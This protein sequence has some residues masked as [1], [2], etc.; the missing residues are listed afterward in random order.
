MVHVTNISSSTKCVGKYEE[1]IIQCLAEHF[2]KKD[3]EVIPHARFNIAWGIIISD[4][5]LLLLKGRVL[6]YVEVKS[7]RDKLQ[8][9]FQQIERVKDFVDYAYVATDKIVSDWDDPHVGLI[10]V[11]GSLVT[12][13]KE[14][15]QFK[16]SPSFSSIASLRKKCLLRFIENSH[17]C[18]NYIY[19]YDLAQH[20]HNFMR[21][22]CNRELLKEIVTCG[23]TCDTMCP[24]ESCVE[25]N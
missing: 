24:I 8:R 3:Y 6:I 10:S 23:N 11:N 9:A 18:S 13:V 15:K 25:R 19:K 1:K 2:R 12:L 22:K 4:I 14:T 5:D 21:D 17:A 7:R 20:I 16:N